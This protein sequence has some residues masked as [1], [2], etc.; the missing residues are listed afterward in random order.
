MR[1]VR[2]TIVHSR[3]WGGIEAVFAARLACVPVVI[4]SE[5]GYQL[6]MLAGLPLRQRMLRHL[7]YRTATAV[8]TVTRELRSY[9][10]AQAWIDPDRIRVLYNGV[11]GEI[12]K[13]RP[14]I[15]IAIRR[16]L[17]IPLDRHVVG[18]VGRLVPL[19]DAITLLKAVE[20]LVAKPP[21]I[22]ALLVGSGPELARLQEYVSRS[23]QL[24]GRVTFTGTAENVADVLNAMDVFVLPSLKEGMSN[25]LLE[26][27]ASG[28]PVVATRV[29]GNPEIIE[30]GVCGC[31]FAPGDAEELIRKI[32]VLLQNRGL[33]VQFGQSAREKA[34]EQF[35]LTGM[36]NRYRDLYAGLAGQGIPAAVGEAYVRN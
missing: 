13:P 17:D 16:Q 23:P 22:H 2:P 28:L 30:E 29:G 24:H 25:T 34:L 12:F 20:A 8:F 9:H 14:K 32:D 35:S 33:R 18:F 31:L 27:L 15:G 11:D 36:L 5:H 4:H 1:K 3:A 19:K 21:E 7:A 10:A 6:E 26:A